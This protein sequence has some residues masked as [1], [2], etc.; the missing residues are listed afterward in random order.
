[1]KVNFLCIVVLLTSSIGLKA[2]NI[3]PPSGFVGLGATSSLAAQLHINASP[4]Q[5]FRIYQSG[6]GTTNYLSAWQGSSA[7]AIE[8]VGTGQLYL[9]YDQ[10]TN[11]FLSPAGGNVGIGTTSPGANLEAVSSGAMAIIKV[12]HSTEQPDWGLF[13]RQTSD[14]KGL[15]ACAGRDLQIESGLT[16]SL[17]LGDQQYDQYSGKVIFPG[18]K[19]GIGTS[20]PQEKLHVAGNVFIANNQMQFSSTSGGNNR[21][22]SVYGDY[23]SVT[24]SWNFKSRFDNIVLDAGE[25]AG[26]ERQIIFK[27]AGTQRM[28]VTTDGN[29][30][31][32]TPTTGSY[33]LAVEGKIGAREINVTLASWSDYVFENSYKLPSLEELAAYIRVNKHLPEVP[34]ASDVEKQ[35]VNL[36]EMN[37]LLLKKV[38]ELTLYLIEQ[39]KTNFEQSTRI[40]QLESKIESLEN[41]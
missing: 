5:S 3:Y 24:G 10:P 40:S 29:V 19:I 38:E 13:M 14:L 9:G 15:I 6:G 8:A 18:G 12:R 26:N 16:N 39:Q 23:N 1:M 20:T 7:S 33:K 37:A 11:I 36:G 28:T 30:G 34:S 32:G 31:I 4:R 2:Q 22:Q 27:T 35:G 25:N 17:I 41:K 21:I